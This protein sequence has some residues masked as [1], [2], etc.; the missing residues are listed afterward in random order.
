MMITCRAWA[1]SEDVRL[2]AL[3]DDGSAHVFF[4]AHWRRPDKIMGKCFSRVCQQK[5]VIN[6]T[7]I[8][9]QA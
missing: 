9:K 5:A 7:A 1:V 2:K 4:Q 8:E 3:A 6:K